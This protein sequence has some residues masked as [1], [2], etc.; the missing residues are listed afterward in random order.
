MK[1]VAIWVFGIFG[2]TVMGALIGE[3]ISPANGA[4]PGALVGFCLFACVRFFV[5]VLP[6]NQNL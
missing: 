1:T 6:S 2:C 4:G 5:P 3:M